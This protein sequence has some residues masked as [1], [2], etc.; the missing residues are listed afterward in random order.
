MGQAPQ[1]DRLPHTTG[2][3]DMIEAILLFWVILWV[4]SLIGSFGGEP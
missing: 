3:L 4:I 2:G 1:A